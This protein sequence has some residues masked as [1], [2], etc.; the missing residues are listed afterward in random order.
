METSMLKPS[1]ITAGLLDHA[2][3]MTLAFPQENYGQLALVFANGEK[4]YGFFLDGHEE[5]LH[6]MIA[7]TDENDWNCALV[8][9][10]EIELDPNSSYNMASRY[11]PIGS[12]VRQ[13]EDLAVQTSNVGSRLP[14]LG[15]AFVIVSGLPKC[16]PNQK[17]CF[18]RWQIVLGQGIEKRILHTVDVTPP[19][20]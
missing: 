10:V 8:P 15:N 2:A 19:G 11:P 20:S 3:P 5:Y 13:G 6:H 1:E 14:H 4:K 9:G 17:A 18:T 16:A 12:L 7:L